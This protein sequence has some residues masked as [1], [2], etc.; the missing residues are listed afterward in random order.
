MIFDLFD[1]LRLLSWKYKAALS[2]LILC[3]TNSSCLGIWVSNSV[4]WV[5]QSAALCLRSF[6]EPWPGNS[7]LAEA[8]VNYQLV[9]TTGTCHIPLQGL[10]QVLLQLL[11][12]NT[13]WKE[14]K[15]KS[16]MRHSVLGGK[17]QD[18]SSDSYIFSRDDVMSPT[19]VSFYILYGDNCSLWLEESFMKLVETFWN[20]CCDCMYS[21]FI[22]ITY[23]LFSP[24]S[25]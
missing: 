5:G 2:S 17:P 16:I 22:K 10:K 25:L 12:F 9:F 8:D 4:S 19:L 11:I 15:V 14:F 24:P 23:I 6:Y 1:N 13:P 21:S 3:P 7:A 20:M 18:R